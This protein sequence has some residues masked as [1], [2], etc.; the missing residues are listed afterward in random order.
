MATPI[1]VCP[2]GSNFDAFA[3]SVDAPH[4]MAAA[5]AIANHQWCFVIA[6]PSSDQAHKDTRPCR[7]LDR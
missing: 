4:G 2:A 1:T 6:V 3:G 5:S 7:L